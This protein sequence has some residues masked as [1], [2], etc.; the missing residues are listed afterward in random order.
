MKLLVH[1]FILH[2]YQIIT[3]E[4]RQVDTFSANITKN[5]SP[6]GILKIFSGFPEY[7]LSVVIRYLHKRLEMNREL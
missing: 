4:H 2:G 6:V 7:S 1:S 5:V 3:T